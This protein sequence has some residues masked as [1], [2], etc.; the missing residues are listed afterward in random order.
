M[1]ALQP[2]SYPLVQ[3]FLT[4]GNGQ[5]QKVVLRIEDYRRLLEAIEDEGLYRAMQNTRR[6]RSLSKEAALGYLAANES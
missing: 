5:V 1:E 3:E 6:E 2:E 4:D